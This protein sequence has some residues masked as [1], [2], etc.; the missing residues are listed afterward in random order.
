MRILPD[1][2]GQA[3]GPADFQLGLID[4]AGFFFAAV[5]AEGPQERL[6]RAEHA[7]LLAGRF[8]AEAFGFC[9]FWEFL[10]RQADG[11]G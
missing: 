10:V 8:R 5:V 3:F 2:R 9:P 7:E 4:E 11:S 1:L 6:V